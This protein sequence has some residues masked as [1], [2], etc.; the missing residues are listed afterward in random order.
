MR[1]K[2]LQILQKIISG[3]ARNQY[4]EKSFV[5]PALGLVLGLVALVLLG[6]GGHIWTLGV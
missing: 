5:G 1:H 3:T 4:L 6:R 2:A